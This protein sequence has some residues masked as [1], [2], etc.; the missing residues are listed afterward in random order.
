M[1]SPLWYHHY[2]ITIMVSPLWYHHYGITIIV[3]PSWHHHHGITIMVSPPWYYHRD[4]TIM[5]PTRYHH[6]DITRWGECG[7]WVSL[8]VRRV[9]IDNVIRHPGCTTC[10]HLGH[11][12]EYIRIIFFTFC[13]QFD[14]KCRF[15]LG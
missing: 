12:L 10:C 14:V 1:V 13:C 5:V 9:H 8:P 6:H 7:V 3:L 4:I 11:D 2:G 15:G